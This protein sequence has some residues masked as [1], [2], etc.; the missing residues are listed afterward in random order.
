MLD[1]EILS[2]VL[3]VLLLMLLYKP[4]NTDGFDSKPERHQAEHMAS[5]MMDNRERFRSLDNVRRTM[6]WMDAVTY[7]DSR[8]LILGGNFTKQN[9]LGILS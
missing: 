8:R 6:P 9:I 1:N 3:V 2:I 4:K 5:Q 7:E